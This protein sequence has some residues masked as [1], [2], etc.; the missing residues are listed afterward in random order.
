MSID[1]YK[2][3]M[4]QKYLSH[5]FHSLGEK[6]AFKVTYSKHKKACYKKTHVA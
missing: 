5:I 4:Q 2:L 3:N 1:T 6:T